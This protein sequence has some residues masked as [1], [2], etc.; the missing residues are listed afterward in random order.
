M[1]PPSVL[2]ARLGVAR[3]LL[4]Q[5]AGTPTHEALSRAQKDATL[6]VIS[7]ETENVKG[8]SDEDH[9][10]VVTLVASIAWYP[11]HVGDLLAPL[12]QIKEEVERMKDDKKPRRPSQKFTPNILHYFTATEWDRMQTADPHSRSDFLMT[13]ILQLGGFNGNLKLP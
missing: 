8:M 13:R 2:L 7:R 4:Q 6:A 9:A 10:I 3:V 1:A 5:H 12:T 11:G